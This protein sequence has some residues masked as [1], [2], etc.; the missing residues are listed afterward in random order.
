MDLFSF[1]SDCFGG[2]NHTSSINSASGVPMRDRHIDMAGNA[3]GSN[4]TSF[5]GSNSFDS[6][7]NS[8]SFGTSFGSGFS[9]FD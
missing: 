4:S 2:C 5:G 3:F 9:P 1:L 6:F 8:D 7:S